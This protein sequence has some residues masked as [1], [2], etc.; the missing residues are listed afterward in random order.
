[1][2]S[3]PFINWKDVLGMKLTDVDSNKNIVP[4]SLNK[5]I[6]T[7]YKSISIHIYIHFFF[8]IKHQLELNPLSHLWAL[9]S[10]F[11]LYSALLYFPKNKLNMAFLLF[12]TLYTINIRSVFVIYFYSC[13]CIL[14]AWRDTKE[15]ILCVFS[16]SDNLT[17]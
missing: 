1:M 6:K 7:T 2:Y 17:R 4:K 10:N 14:L 13:S 11:L 15:V 5:I 3:F 9:H 8:Q 16:L 12:R